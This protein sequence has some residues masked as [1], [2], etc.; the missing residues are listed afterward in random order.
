[1]NGILEFSRISR[2]FKENLFLGTSFISSQFFFFSYFD[3]HGCGQTFFIKS[4]NFSGFQGKKNFPFSLPLE[5][6]KAILLINPKET[7]QIS[8]IL[9]KKLFSP[10]EKQK[11]KFMYYQKWSCNSGEKKQ[12]S[13][14]S[15]NKRLQ[16]EGEQIFSS[17]SPFQTCNGSSIVQY[18]K[19][20]KTNKVVVCIAAARR[21]Q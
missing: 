10:S 5:Q 15:H 16:K 9:L 13:F 17:S 6:G 14:N 18:G 3:Q 2:D 11:Q 8:R 1:M 20:H 12:F 4:L 7:A 19:V 21:P